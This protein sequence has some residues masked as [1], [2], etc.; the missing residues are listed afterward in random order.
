M[1]YNTGKQENGFAAS[2]LLGRTAGDGYV[3]G[4]EFEGFNYF[5]GLGYEPNDKHNFQFI[6][7]GGTPGS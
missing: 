7:T 2:V 6:L 3:Q 5:I 4:T 1:A